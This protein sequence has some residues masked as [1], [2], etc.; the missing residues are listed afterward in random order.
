MSR[1]VVSL[2][3]GLAATVALAALSGPVW[4]MPV[5]ASYEQAW[6]KYGWLDQQDAATA[7]AT[8]SEGYVYVGGRTG[9]NYYDEPVGISGAVL[10][11]YTPSGERIWLEKAYDEYGSDSVG[12]VA[13]DASNNIFIAGATYRFATGAE[14]YLAKFD[15]NGNRLWNQ[16]L[17]RP[18]NQFGNDVAVDAQGNAYIVGQ[19][20]QLLEGRL[21]S[22]TG[23][24]FVAKYAPNGDLLW[25]T[26]LGETI[27]DRAVAVAVDASGNLLLGRSNSGPL[28]IFTKMSPNGD[29]IWHQTPDYASTSG[30]FSLVR[31]V[32]SDAFD[33]VY[34]AGYTDAENHQWGAG[35]DAFL[36]K[37]DANGNLLWMQKLHTDEHDTISC[38]VVGNSGNLFVSGITEGHLEEPTQ[39]AYDAF[40][41]EYTPSGDLVWLDQFDAAYQEAASGIATGLSGEVYVTGYTSVQ[42][43]D[44]FLTR[45]NF[46]P[47]PTTLSLLL[48]GGLVVALF[49]R[50]T[51]QQLG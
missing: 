51:R 3:V 40:W 2:V 14:A 25:T 16:H 30:L 27:A 31:D 28:G 26:Q 47:E 41:A 6:L 15:S 33:N 19:T 43:G 44:M 18:G 32:A 5:G 7:M 12:G 17:G 39:G 50:R 21:G 23:G 11:K 22:A 10:T 38:V 4:A 45:F 29:V 37:H 24:A 20:T 36:A 48:V 46:V 1:F 49:R 13:I 35:M 34:V 9:P 8:D 42:N